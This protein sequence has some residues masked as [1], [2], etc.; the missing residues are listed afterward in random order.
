MENLTVFINYFFGSIFVGS[1]FV[2]A[3]VKLLND[4]FDSKKFHWH[5]FTLILTVA[6]FL[7]LKQFIPQETIRLIVNVMGLIVINYLFLNKNIKFSITSVLISDVVLIIAELIFALIYSAAIDPSAT[8]LYTS[9][10]NGIIINLIIAIIAMIIF[11]VKKIYDLSNL[12]IEYSNES[13]NKWIAI[14]SIFFLA[15]AIFSTCSSYLQWNPIYVLII[16]MVVICLFLFTVTRYVI[17]Q[18]ELEKISSKYETSISSLKEYEVMIDKF[19]VDT[20]ENKNEFRTIRNMLKTKEDKETVIK[21]IDKLIDNKI[22]DNVQIMKKT[23]KIPEGGLRATIYSKLC[24][25]D[26][27]NIKYRLNISRDVSTTD[28][29]NLDENLILKICKILGVFL[30]NAI[31]AVKKLKKKDIIVE[32]YIMN[33]NLCIDI[34]NNFKG[35]L[36]LEK[37]SNVKYTTKGEG[38]GYGLTLVE[39]ILNE[40][41]EK[42]ENEK[43]INRDTF[44][45][46]LKIKM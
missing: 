41:T 32:I 16:N 43:S 36:D 24:L 40:E 29:I 19:R 21:Y 2:Y 27:L 1:F 42:L 26:K 7:T 17:K 22:K 46:T 33:D 20:H 6:L 28:L 35:N 44:T 31:E 9:G 23:A 25:M 18:K 39:N 3:W 11:N 15:L 38:H 8:I 12:L 45:Q 10:Y 34:T 4:D 14:Y 5:I 30:D 13:K 37:I